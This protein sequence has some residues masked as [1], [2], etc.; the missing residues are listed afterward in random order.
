MRKNAEE[1]INSQKKQGGKR[2]CE[3]EDRTFV[4]ISS[5]ENHKWMDGWMDEISLCD[6]WDTIKRNS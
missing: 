6:L 3:L 4:I 2:I 5:E 1:I